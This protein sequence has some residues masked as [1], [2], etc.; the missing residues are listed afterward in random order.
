[1]PIDA[2]GCQKTIA[3]QIVD[4][5]AAYVL[6]LKPTQ[7][8]CYP[9]VERWVQTAD[10]TPSEE[11]ALSY[12]ATEEQ[13]HGRGELRRP[14]T[15]PVP[16]GLPLAEAWAKLTSV[17]RV[18]SERHGQGEVTVEQRYSLAS[19][20]SEAQRLAHAVRAHWGIENWVHWV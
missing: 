3:K 2:R 1:M 16:V 13:R 7:G 11:A 5:G 19:L 10:H 4:Q 18:E 9:A 6:A 14:W 17:G 20:A 8:H 12:Y 15:A